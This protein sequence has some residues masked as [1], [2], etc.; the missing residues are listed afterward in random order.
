MCETCEIAEQLNTEALGGSFQLVDSFFTLLSQRLPRARFEA[1]TAYHILINSTPPDE[2][3][4]VDVPDIREFADDFR[5]NY[6]Q[7]I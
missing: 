5:A 4:D 3:I 1:F 7:E 2:A 6:L